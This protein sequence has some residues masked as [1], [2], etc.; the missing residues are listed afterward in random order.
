MT[1]A[2]ERLLGSI[3]AELAPIALSCDDI[4]QELRRLMAGLEAR[5]SRPDALEIIAA[6]QRDAHCTPIGSGGEP[7]GVDQG[8]G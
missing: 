1:E 6:F 2:N 3:R 7:G 5:P 8:P 4:I